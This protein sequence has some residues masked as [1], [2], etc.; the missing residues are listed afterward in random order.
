MVGHLSAAAHR[1]SHGGPDTKLQG[2]K[3]L[4]QSNFLAGTAPYGEEL[5]QEQ[6]F[7]Q[8][9]CPVGWDPEWNSVFLKY[10][11]SWEGVGVE[12]SLSTV[13]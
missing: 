12:Q 3:T 7:W 10:C 2:I 4:G 6:I 9:L 13:A 11:T 1:E 5:R 8:D